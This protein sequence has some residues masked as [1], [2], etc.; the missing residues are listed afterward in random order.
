[1][2]NRPP[3]SGWN[4]DW[5]RSSIDLREL[6]VGIP[7]ADPRDAI[8]P[9]DIAFFES[10]DAASQWLVGR[11][12]VV[13]LELGGEAR[14]YPL[15]ILTRHEIVNDEVGGISI[16]VTFCPLCNSAAVF[17]RTVEGQVLRFGVSGLLRKSDLVMWD[18]QTESLWQ[19]ITGE[20]IVGELTGTQLAFLPS[21]VIGFEEF[22][23]RFPDGKVMSRDTGYPFA[24][25]RNGYTQYDSSSRPFLFDG[26]LD[27]RFPALERVVG[28]TVGETNKAYP[29]SLLSPVRAVN[30]EL[31]GEPVLVLWGAED[32]ASALDAAVIA[33]GRSVGV[34]VAYLP[35]LDGQV[36]TFEAQGD[37]T[38]VDL[39]TRSIW[40]LLGKAIDGPLAGSELTPAIHA[41]H[42]WFAWAAFFPD[43]PV[44]AGAAGATA[45]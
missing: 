33:E 21:S 22:R 44:Y 42:F 26:E 36:L 1:V 45:P 6:I 13:L 4:T 5:T 37:D 43:S 28:V 29:F 8:A 34:G 2:Q 7:Y 24:Y 19:Q 20:A 17:D 30:D 10:V 39:E 11:E 31:E 32:T 23:E 40:D 3:V 12:P 27:D 35:T 38:F 9:L 18:R 15:Q 41:N 25:G 16:A 14:A